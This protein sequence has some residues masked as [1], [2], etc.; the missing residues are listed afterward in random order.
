MKKP[1]NLENIR[2]M[3]IERNKSEKQRLALHNAFFQDLTGKRFNRLV[4]LKFKER[5]IGGSKW[6]CLC[7][8][9]KISFVMG[10][11][12]KNGRTKSCGCF[13]REQITKHGFSGTRFFQTYRSIK[14]RC[15][16]PNASKYHLYGGK[17]I[18]ILWDSFKDFK[19][20][21]YKN[22]LGHV[23]K[24]GEYETQIDRIDGNKH[25]CKENCRWVTRLE[26]ARNIKTAKHITYQGK[27][28]YL[29]EWAEKFNLRK[30]LIYSR[31]FE[32]N[33]SI[34]KALT[35]PAK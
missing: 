23:Q 22:Y 5:K 6:E 19:N 7:D 8:C 21:M 3:L 24:F 26:Q 2:K 25:Y 27:T 32:R 1:R 30:K 16:N 4:V 11:K 28:L 13:N 35:T 31:I 9:G 29:G 17:G 33:W 14:Y 15:S 10:S 18:K 34:E 12:L 20:D